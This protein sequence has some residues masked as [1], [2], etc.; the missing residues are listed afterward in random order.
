MTI[1]LATISRLPNRAIRD[2]EDWAWLR[3][4]QRDAETLAEWLESQ[5]AALRALAQGR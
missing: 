2:F 5:P 4:V 3:N 1:Y